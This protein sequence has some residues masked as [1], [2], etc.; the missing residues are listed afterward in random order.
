MSNRVSE[1]IFRN[2]RSYAG[3]AGATLAMSTAAQASTIVY[4]GPIDVTANLGSGRPAVALASFSINDYLLQARVDAG[5]FRSASA[6]LIGSNEL[7]RFANTFFHV[8]ARKYAA[9]Q[10]IFFGASTG[11]SLGFALLTS[12]V[13]FGS[14]GQR[15][16]F[17]VSGT[18][19]VS[20]Y[21]GFRDPANHFGWIQ[22]EV[23]TIASAPR[24]IQVLG[25]AYDTTANEAILAGDTGVAAAPEPGTIGLA[26]LGLGAAGIAAWRR[27]RGEVAA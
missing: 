4:S 21:V 19:N 10:A 24:E 5:T 6:I 16:Q 14:Y 22:V 9:G 11:R 18:G 13:G 23:S 12:N 26:V 27:R 20:G 1:S 7:L 17:A 25:Y 8:T 15:G 2:W 3:A